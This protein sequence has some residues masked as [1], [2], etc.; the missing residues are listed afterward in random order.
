MLA[1]GLIGLLAFVIVKLQLVQNARW[2]VKSLLASL[3]PAPNDTVHGEDGAGSEEGDGKKKEDMEAGE[4]KGEED[5][6]E[7]KTVPLLEVP[8]CFQIAF[9]LVWRIERQVSGL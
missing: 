1:S 9:Q 8:E 7:E 2:V 5:K 6:E 3:R 4:E